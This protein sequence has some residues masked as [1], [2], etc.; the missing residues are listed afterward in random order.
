MKQNFGQSPH[1]EKESI[2]KLADRYHI[3][4]DRERIDDEWYFVG[5]VA[6]FPDVAVFEST[7][8]AAYESAHSV[9]TGLLEA[10]RVQRR[11]PPTPSR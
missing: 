4:V 6:E 10:Y 2:G 7:K 5:R 3:A 8:I 11:S 9:V 1:D